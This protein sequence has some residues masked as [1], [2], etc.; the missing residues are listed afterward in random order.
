MRDKSCN[1]ISWKTKLGGT[2]KGKDWNFKHEGDEDWNN[3]EFYVKVL[4][5]AKVTWILKTYI[6][7][8]TSNMR[9]SLCFTQ[10]QGYSAA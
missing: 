1:E 2:L 7:V 9:K 5:Q 10:E 6:S 3:K 4:N 8:I